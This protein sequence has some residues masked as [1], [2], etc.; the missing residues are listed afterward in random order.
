MTQPG[1][2]A[3]VLRYLRA[4]LGPDADGPSDAEPLGRF[5]TDRD[6]GAFELLVWR[7]SGTVLRVGRG[8]LRDHHAAED[9]AQAAL[10][11][12]PRKA[13]SIGRRSRGPSWPTCRSTRRS[14][15]RSWSDR[16]A[17]SCTSP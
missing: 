6:Q 7:Y 8:V 3:P 17:R 12:Q 1:S 4:A 5:V 13:G 15:C 10:L 9:V 11:V 16:S 14:P 2:P